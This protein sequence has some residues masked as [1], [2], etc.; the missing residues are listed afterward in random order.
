MTLV[1]GD[2]QLIYLWCTILF[3]LNSQSTKFTEVFIFIRCVLSKWCLHTDGWKKNG[4][5]QQWKFTMWNQVYRQKQK[6]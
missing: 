2:P 1:K 3:S 6:I 4:C 5:R